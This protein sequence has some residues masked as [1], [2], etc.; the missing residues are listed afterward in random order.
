MQRLWDDGYSRGILCATVGTVG[1]VILE[2][3]Q[4]YRWMDKA[5]VQTASS[6]ACNFSPMRRPSAGYGDAMARHSTRQR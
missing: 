1:D 3:L 5:G 6:I 2:N 4:N